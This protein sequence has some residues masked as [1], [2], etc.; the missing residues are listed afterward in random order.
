MRYK[1]LI[2][3]VLFCV[4]IVITMEVHKGFEARVLNTGDKVRM[5]FVS[6]WDLQNRIGHTKTERESARG[7]T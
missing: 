4:T 3:L 6:G 1:V 2:F 5:F 7:K